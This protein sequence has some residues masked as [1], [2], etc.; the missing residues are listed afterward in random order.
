MDLG[1][2]YDPNVTIAIP[3]TKKKM[4]DEIMDIEEVTF[5]YSYTLTK[6]NDSN[7]FI[8]NQAKNIKNEPNEEKNTPALRKLMEDANQKSD[9][10]HNLN[11]N[12]ALLVFF[13]EKSSN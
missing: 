1:L 7:V 3:K 10:K 4:Q 9:K 8:K 6:P 2:S 11:E 13:F 5:K 12:D